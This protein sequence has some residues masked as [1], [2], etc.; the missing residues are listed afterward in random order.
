[1]FEKILVPIDGS[2]ISERCLAQAARLAKIHG[3]RMRLVHVFTG[4]LYDHAMEPGQYPTGLLATLRGCAE[5]ILNRAARQIASQGVHVEQAM[6]ESI[7]DPAAESII[8]DAKLWQADVIVMGTH[9]RR[10]YRPQ[11]LG[12]D[13][14]AV[15]RNSSIPVILVRCVA[16]RATE[17]MSLAPQRRSAAR[18]H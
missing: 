4:T 6:I 17:V 18:Q 10:G 8:V 1:M 11:E 15:L 9:G 5:G 16:D 13:A 3:S 2:E 12:T 14:S 7:G